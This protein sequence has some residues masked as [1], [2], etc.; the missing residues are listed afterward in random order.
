MQPNQEEKPSPPP[1]GDEEWTRDSEEVRTSEARFRNLFRSMDQ[2]SCVVEILFDGSGKAV[3]FRFLEANPAFERHTGLKD[4]VD[5]TVRELAPGLEDFWFETYGRVAESGEP[6]RFERISER[7]GGRWFHVDAFRLGGPDS[8]QVAIMFSDVSDRR[9]VEGE[10]RQSEERHRSILESITDGFFAVDRDWR[11]TYVNPQFERILDQSAGDVLGESLWVLYPGLAES[12]FGEIY[13]RVAATRVAESATAHYADF[14]RWFEFNAYPAVDGLSVYFRDVT[15]RML[16]EQALRASERRFRELADAAPAILW[17]TEPDGRCTFLSRGW[18]ELTGQAE[19]EALGIGWVDAL[20]PE[21]QVASGRAFLAAN[22]RRQMFRCEYRVR[23]PDGSY[24]WAL[25]V[26]RPRFASDGSFLG[27]VGSVI[28]VHERKLAEEETRR[29]DARVNLALDSARLGTWNIDPA[30]EA[31]ETDDR[32]RA[33]FGVAGD[34][35]SYQDAVAIVHP[36]DRARVLEAILASTRP[37]DPQPYSLEY[38]VVH[39]DGSVRWVYVE[40]RSNFT[41]EGSGRRLA[42]FDGTIAD[43][44]EK[45]RAEDERRELTA[46]IGLQARIFDTALSNSPDFIYTFDLAGRFTYIN[47]ALLALWGKTS[48]EAVGKNFFD[49]DYPIDLAA[50]LQRQIQQVVATRAHVRDETPYTSA[51]GERRYDYIF[52]PVLAP[53]GTVEAVAGSTRDVTERTQAEEATRKRALQLQKLAEIATRVNAAHD[54]SSVVGV[55]T[56]EA[57]LLIGARQA[58]TCMVLGTH[59]PYPLNVVSTAT[60]RSY[61]AEEPGILGADLYMVVNA[62]NRPVRL[63]QDELEHDARWRILQKVA[64]VKPS[65]GGWLAAPLLGRNGRNLGL[66]QLADKLDGEFT[67]DDEAMLVQLSRLAAI[68]VENAR[69]YQELRSNDAR[70]DEFLAMLAHELR[71]PLAAIGNAVKVTTKS[72][73]KEH[74]DW[75]ME[76]ITRQMQHLSRLIDDLM[77]VS[78]ITRGKIELRRSV[79]EITPILESAAATVRTLVDERKHTLELDV[80]RAGLWADVD[81]TRMEQVVVN[82]LNNAAKYSD[83]G[84]RIRLSARSELDEVVVAVT[85]RGVGIPPEKI[86][87]MFELFAQGDRSLARSEG[88]LGIGLTVVKKLVEMHGGTVTAHSAGAG[89]GSEF[90]IRLPR[91]RWTPEASRS[92]D[93]ARAETG[94]KVR[95][96]VVDDNV[97]TAWGMAMLLELLGHQVATAHSGPAAIEAATATPPDFILLDIGLPGMSGYEVASRLRR[98]ACCKDV[99]IVAVS[100]YGQDEDRRRSKAAG[101]DHHLTKPLDHDALLALLAD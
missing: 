9:R 7:L 6:A 17:V 20:H 65:G 57:R 29:L 37:D 24:R 91:A 27:F 87:E 79:M 58:A 101:F 61:A 43:V 92:A 34:H 51:A 66:L 99:V 48:D 2:A 64:L 41:G 15:D 49:L 30:T 46:R 40:G 47:R 60:N 23:R 83:D 33:I 52:V 25:D 14:D 70:K 95:I 81:P 55:V 19:E 42:S 3:D 75:S 82:L 74:I 26:G 63:T 80:E 38:R 77:D 10:L 90:V 96:L 89:E 73:L 62:E 32:F 8:R 54:V 18:H 88:G 44:T 100:G 16:A 50:R 76:V 78:R 28:D 45:K 35:C 86:P 53:D 21:D 22:E 1:P 94:R 31:L 39:A 85:D 98:E 36:D 68:A 97:D 13:R 72:G 5:R 93:A 11:F 69:L 59:H 71:N 12:E 4:V 56:E 84:G 67:A